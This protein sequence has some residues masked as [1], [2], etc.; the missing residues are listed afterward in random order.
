MEIAQLVILATGIVSALVSVVIFLDR[1]ADRL[2]GLRLQ[3]MEASYTRQVQQLHDQYLARL[4]AQEH[5]YEARIAEYDRLAKLHSIML[6]RGLDVQDLTIKELA[7]RA[8]GK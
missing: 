6:T 8:R 2:Y 5:Q 4:A 1:R 3:E 7:P